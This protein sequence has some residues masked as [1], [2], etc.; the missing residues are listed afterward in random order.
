MNWVSRVDA[1]VRQNFD[2]NEAHGYAHVSRVKSIAESIWI[3]E[4]GDLELIQISA[5]LHDCYAGSRS[6][7]QIL[8][9]IQ[10]PG[11]SHSE[12]CAKLAGQVLRAIGY[13]RANQVIQAILSHG[14]T[15]RY[16]LILEWSAKFLIHGP[17]IARMLN[18]KLPLEIASRYPPRSL[19]SR[20]LWDADAIDLLE[21]SKLNPDQTSGFLWSFLGFYPYI[22]KS[23]YHRLQT[24]AGKAIFSQRYP[25]FIHRFRELISRSG[26]EC[27]MRILESSS[28]GAV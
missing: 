25:Q 8:D 2:R 21:I 15:I 13:S 17:R 28:T 10:I 19:E 9:L 24:S 6:K 1:I 16:Q 12:L 14:I 20:I 26:T 4:G 23:A 27:Q 5:L 18:F 11:L 22:L 3:K 7:L